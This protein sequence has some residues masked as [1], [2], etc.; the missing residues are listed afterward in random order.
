MTAEGLEPK[1]DGLDGSPLPLISGRPSN[2][3]IEMWHHRTHADAGVVWCR[4]P[5]RQLEHSNHA[6]VLGR[7]SEADC[8]WLPSV[9]R[10]ALPSKDQRSSA[11]SRLRRNGL[12]QNY[13]IGANWHLLGGEPCG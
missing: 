2:Q 5:V 11:F 10:I 7:R 12:W 9:K 3:R 6:L 4:K 8:E 1:C 13:S